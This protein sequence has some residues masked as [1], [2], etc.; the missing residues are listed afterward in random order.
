M[1]VKSQPYT[2]IIEWLNCHLMNKKKKHFANKYHYYKTF[3]N[4]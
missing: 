4:W 1:K 2:I 3:E